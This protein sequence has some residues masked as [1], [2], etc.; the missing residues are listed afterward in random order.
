M[1]TNSDYILFGDIWSCPLNNILRPECNTN[2]YLLIFDRT[3]VV[4]VRMNVSVL[5]LLSFQNVHR[6]RNTC[7][8]ILCVTTTIITV[9][10]YSNFSV[11]LT[12][13][14]ATRKY[15]MTCGAR[16]AR[17]WRTRKRSRV[18]LV[19]SFFPHFVLRII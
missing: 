16:H 11:W 6:T 13:V 5:K 3:S 15:T 17:L 19:R 8:V 14:R 4:F 9:I 12:S 18:A 1:E 7:V 10:I 2:C